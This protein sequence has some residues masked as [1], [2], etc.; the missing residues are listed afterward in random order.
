MLVYE[1][2]SPCEPRET[3]VTLI[4]SLNENWKNGVFLHVDMGVEASREILII[5]DE[6]PDDVDLFVPALETYAAAVTTVIC[7]PTTMEEVLVLI[8]LRQ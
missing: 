8:L 1:T 3:I 7:E 4:K 5:G 6:M 2:Y